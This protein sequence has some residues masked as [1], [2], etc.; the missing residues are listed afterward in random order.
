[1]VR[2]FFHLLEQTSALQGGAETG[3]LSGL[4]YGWG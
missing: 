4:A 1:M 2:L 3:R